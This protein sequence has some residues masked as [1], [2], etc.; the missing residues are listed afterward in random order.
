MQYDVRCAVAVCSMPHFLNV[1]PPFACPLSARLYSR[2]GESDSVQS[3]ARVTEGIYTHVRYFATPGASAPSRQRRGCLSPS[4][5]P[6]ISDFP[7]FWQRTCALCPIPVTYGHV[8]AT[9]GCASRAQAAG[10]VQLCHTQKKVCGQVRPS[11]S[12]GMSYAS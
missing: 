5:L 12:S 3:A 8:L 2:H 6:L 7:I 10:C 4:S 1:R 9:Y 11:A